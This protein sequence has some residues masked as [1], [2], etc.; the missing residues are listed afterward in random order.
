MHRHSE[1]VST[2][3]E[4]EVAN[5]RSGAFAGPLTTRPAVEN[6]E[7]WHGQTKFVLSNPV[8]VQVSCVQMV[9]NA[10][11]LSCPVRATRN[12]PL[13]ARTIAAPPT[14]ASG[15][16]ESICTCTLPALAV[17]FAVVS[18]G[19]LLGPDPPPPHAAATAPSARQEAA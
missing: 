11:K 6:R 1:I 18:C 10:L 14:V 19:T 2:L 5:D 16:D 12:A 13:D 7:P 15:D 4:K 8:I 17:P 3:F 9:V